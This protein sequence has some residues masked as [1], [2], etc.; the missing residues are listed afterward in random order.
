MTSKMINNIKKKTAFTLT[1]ILT[2]TAIMMISSWIIS[3]WIS[4]FWASNDILSAEWVFTSKVRSEKMSVISWEVRCSEIELFY[5]RWYFSIF[6]WDEWWDFCEKNIFWKIKRG[7]KENEDEKNNKIIITLK[8]DNNW[9]FNA[10]IDTFEVFTNW[11]YL[12]N[13]NYNINSNSGVLV[14][15]LLK[16]ENLYKVTAENLKW[17]RESIEVVFFNWNPLDLEENPSF[18]LVEKIS[19]MSFKNKEIVWNNLTISFLPDKDWIIK[20]RWIVSNNIK[21]NLSNVNWEETFFNFFSASL[22]NWI[23]N[24][25][26]VW[27]INL[28][29]ILK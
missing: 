29:N 27:E 17:K 8:K 6:N 9:D 13:I 11:S 4:S 25:I 16:D 19:W 2:V 14:F 21:I 18:V 26:K 3:V 22:L 15:E 23:Q 7:K 10:N 28:D 20:L 5:W 1:E 12:R 24:K